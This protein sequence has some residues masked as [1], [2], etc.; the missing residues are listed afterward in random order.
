[1]I[2]RE[3][4]P[5]SD[6]TIGRFRLKVV[7]ACLAALLVHGAYGVVCSG[8]LALYALIAAGIALFSG[9][10]IDAPVFNHWDEAVWLLFLAHGMRLASLGFS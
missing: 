7:F 4:D 2:L 9:Q 1:M 10:K 5:V 3:L 8:W 6:A